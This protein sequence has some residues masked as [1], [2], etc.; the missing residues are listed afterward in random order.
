MSRDWKTLVDRCRDGLEPLVGRCPPRSA[1]VDTGVRR[2]RGCSARCIVDG[3]V[4]GGDPFVLCELC[5]EGV[6]LE[7]ATRR[8][9][10]RVA[11][12]VGRGRVLRAGAL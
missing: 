6:E 12:V 1:K 2:C 10:E 11:A 9:R 4:T 7:L 5:A 8:R 3:R